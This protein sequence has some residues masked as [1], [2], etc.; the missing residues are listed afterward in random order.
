MKY[1]S[2]QIRYLA[3]IKELSEN[4]EEVRSVSIARHLG[5][6]RAGVSKMLRCMANSG[7]VYEDYSSN[8]VLTPD[9]IEAVEEI[10]RSYKEVYIFF[11]NFL[12]LTHEEAHD[13]ALLF[14]TD[15]PKESTDRLRKLVRNTVKKKSK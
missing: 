9:G 3:A 2:G 1:C 12:K 10:F 4:N 14:I 8:V 6:S 5:V 11:R 15:F 7:L 13:Q